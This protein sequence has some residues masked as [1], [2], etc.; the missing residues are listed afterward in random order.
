MTYKKDFHNIGPNQRTGPVRHAGSRVFK[1][2]RRL[3][4]FL[5]PFVAYHVGGRIPPVLAGYKITHRCNL[6]CRPCPYWR[7]SGPEQNF[8]GVKGTLTRLREMGVRILI[9]EGGEPLLWRDGDKSLRDVIR[10]AR[11]LFPSVCVTTNGTL[12][13]GHLETDRVWV[14]LDGTRSVHDALRGQP[15]FETIVENLHREGR[16]RAFISTTINTFN[17]ANIPDLVV[18]LKGLVAGITIQFHYPYEGLPDTL[19]IPVPERIQVLDDL[20]RLKR[21]GYP[22]AN[23][24]NS[25]NQLKRPHWACEDKLLANAEPDGRILHGCYLK[26]RGPAVCAFCGFS[27]HNEMS[28]AFKGQW[29][30]IATGLRTF[31]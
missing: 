25:L 23:S 1:S 24:F 29:Q 6:K 9:L 21:D 28:L 12:P 27:A 30:S 11:T 13:W 16:G 8:D 10:F 4:C 5:R 22:V 17:V 19:F 18:M 15:I 14:S 20:I 31:F 3:S 26:N 2:L 7:R